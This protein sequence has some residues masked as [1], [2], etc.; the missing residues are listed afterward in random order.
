MMAELEQEELKEPLGP[1]PS[2]YD[3]K[4]K[5]RCVTKNHTNDTWGSQYSRGI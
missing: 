2:F 3:K 1:S 5:I 4:T